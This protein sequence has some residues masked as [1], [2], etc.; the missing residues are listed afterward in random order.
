MSVEGVAKCDKIVT[1]K[2]RCQNDSEKSWIGKGVKFI[3]VILSD[4]SYFG[5]FLGGIGTILLNDSKILIL[6]RPTFERVSQESTMKNVSCVSVTSN[7][8]STMKVEFPSKSSPSIILS[9]CCSFIISRFSRIMVFTKRLVFGTPC[10]IAS[11]YV[12]LCQ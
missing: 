11:T 4:M 12:E 5:Y 8:T 3:P 9:I 2:K 1:E 6:Q 7:K 10:P